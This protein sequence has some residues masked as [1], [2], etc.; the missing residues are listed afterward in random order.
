M[1]GADLFRHKGDLVLPA[2]V[3][4]RL[5]D[6]FTPVGVVDLHLMLIAIDHEGG[7][8]Y[9]IALSHGHKARREAVA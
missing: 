8:L 9:R 7:E 3:P 6:H 5:R 1:V 2:T 4:L